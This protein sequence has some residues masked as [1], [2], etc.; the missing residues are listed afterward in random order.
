MKKLGNYLLKWI[1][2]RFEYVYLSHSKTPG[3][4]AWGFAF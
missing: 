1:D 3:F 4:G 2:L